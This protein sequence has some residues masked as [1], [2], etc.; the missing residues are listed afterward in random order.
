MPFRGYF[1]PGDPRGPL[2]ASKGAKWPT[3]PAWRYRL[4]SETAT[5][6]WDFLKTTGVLLE[7]VRNFGHDTNRWPA[8]D[9]QPECFTE[10]QLYREWIPLL[11]LLRWRLKLDC[12]CPGAPWELIKT[13]TPGAA[14][15]D[16]PLGRLLT[17]LGP[18]SGVA[19]KVTLYQ[20]EFDEENP[21]GGW[22]PW[23]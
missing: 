11:N 1:R 14:N 19:G 22:P 8:L 15:R 9:G 5:G 7:S 23:G 12:G 4:G 21:P 2:F 17:P 18:G 16:V 6:A 20:V 3:C 10:F 13:T